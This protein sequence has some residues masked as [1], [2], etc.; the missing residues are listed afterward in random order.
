MTIVLVD[1]IG[2]QR[3]NERTFEQAT[4]TIG[5]DASECHVV[6]DQS[7]SVSRRHAELRCRDGR[8]LL[9][10]LNSSFGTF[11][12]GRKIAEPTTVQEGAKLQFGTGGPEVVFW[13]PMPPPGLT[14]RS[15]RPPS[16]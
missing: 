6:F 2:G 7:H 1:E 5:R 13:W 3:K 16:S 10:D 9:V 12:N 8:W 11:V 4:I 15:L 14:R